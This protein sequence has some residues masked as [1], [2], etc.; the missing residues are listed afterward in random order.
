M[1]DSKTPICR[2]RDSRPR[3][4]LKLEGSKPKRE[5][6]ILPMPAA[7]AL[8][9][10]A[11]SGSRPE[12]R[13]A[14]PPR[15]FETELLLLPDGRILVHNLSPEMAALLERLAPQD[16][17]IKR[18]ARSHPAPAPSTTALCPNL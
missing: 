16:A 14:R 7:A 13:D 5:E 17:T 2:C 9:G 3:E 1:S 11:P 6:R 18:R 8:M 12:D 10:A 4:A 15:E